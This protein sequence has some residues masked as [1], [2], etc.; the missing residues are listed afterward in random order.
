MLVLQTDMNKNVVVIKNK[1]LKQKTI[2]V[3]FPFYVH[4]LACVLHFLIAFCF[5]YLIDS[6]RGLAIYLSV[7]I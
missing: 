6:T 1:P 3:T 7:I 2:N 4:L 5:L